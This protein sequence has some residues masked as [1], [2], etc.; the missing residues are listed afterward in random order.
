[1]SILI[2]LLL[3]FE[4]NNSSKHSSIITISSKNIRKHI[5]RR[6]INALYNNSANALINSVNNR[7]ADGNAYTLLV[8]QSFDKL[9]DYWVDNGY[10]NYH[11]YDNY[12]HHRMLKFGIR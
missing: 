11:H 7:K 4:S 1:M 10:R 5:Y 9:Y 6:A 3:V 12:C 2:L 8:Q